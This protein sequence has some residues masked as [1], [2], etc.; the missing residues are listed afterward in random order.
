M[1]IV[2]NVGK[3]SAILQ[4]QKIISVII[5]R[6]GILF[7]GNM[8]AIRKVERRSITAKH[9]HHRAFRSVVLGFIRLISSQDML[10][11]KTKLLR[12]KG[13]V[14]LPSKFQQIFINN[15]IKTFK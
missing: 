11:V 10:K 5:H 15:P 8:K 12:R 3:M 13:W 14:N 9:R 6:S 4:S 1:L 2:L 7:I